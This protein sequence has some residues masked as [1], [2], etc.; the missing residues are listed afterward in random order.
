MLRKFVSHTTRFIEDQKASKIRRIYTVNRCFFAVVITLILSFITPGPLQASGGASK[1]DSSIEVVKSIVSIP[2]TGIPP[3]LLRN[4]SGI[5][6]IPGVIKAG[7]II[8]GRYGTGVLMVKKKDGGWSDPSFIT[9]A[10]GS[11]G[12]QIGV[13]SIDIILVFKNERSI[14]KIVTG[15]FTLGADASIAAGPVGREASAATDA[16]LKSE[17]YSYSRSRGIFA[18]LA[19]AGAVLSIDDEENE[20]FYGRQ[21]IRPREI[22]EGK[23]VKTSLLADELKD[24]LSDYAK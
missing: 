7:F 14:D 2:E 16:E 3:A 17:I 13:E 11:I 5:A 22:F 18:G 24:V 19:L 6:I 4:A 12:W 8:G 15:K 23:G 9:L 1:I 21:G 10:G 20:G